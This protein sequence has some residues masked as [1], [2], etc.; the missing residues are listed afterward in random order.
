MP[1]ILFA[2]NEQCSDEKQEEEI[3]YCGEGRGLSPDLNNCRRRRKLGGSNGKIV[4]EIHHVFPP[5]YPLN[6]EF[7]TPTP[8]RPGSL[9]SPTA[10]VQ[11]SVYSFIPS[12]WLAPCYGGI[13]LLVLHDLPIPPS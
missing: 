2:N 13:F 4:I 9:L 12:Y 1:I 10:H 8:P 6:P 7:V 11:G 3:Y 5:G